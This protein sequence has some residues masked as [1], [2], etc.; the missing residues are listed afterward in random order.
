M[1]RGSIRRTRI[2]LSTSRNTARLSISHMGRWTKSFTTSSWL[3]Y[4]DFVRHTHA[5]IKSNVLF[6][7]EG[8]T[9]YRTHIEKQ[10]NTAVHVITLFL[11]TWAFLIAC[12]PSFVNFRKLF[13]FLSPP[14]PLGQFQPKLAQSIIGWRIFNFV[15]MKVH[16]LFQGK[17]IAKKREYIDEVLKIFSRTTMPI[18]T[19]RHK[20]SCGEGVLHLFKWRP[21]SFFKVRWLRNS[22]DTSPFYLCQAKSFPEYWFKEFKMA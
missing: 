7:S 3:N 21:T 6:V 15:Q 2:P 8:S 16:A 9:I 20:A 17:K 4:R 10:L 18:S 1:Q 19:K 12:R 14:E 13:T 5:I 11:L 22:E